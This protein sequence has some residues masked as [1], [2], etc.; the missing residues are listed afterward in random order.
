MSRSNRCVFLCRAT[1][2]RSPSNT[3]QALY[4]RDGSSLSRSGIE[5]PTSTTPVS[6]Q[7]RRR[8]RR[9]RDSRRARPT[10]R[11]RTRPSRDNSRG[12][13]AKSGL[14]PPRASG[15]W[16]WR[17]DSSTSR[18]ARPAPRR[19]ARRRAP[20][21][22]WRR[23]FGSCRRRRRVDASATFTF[24]GCVARRGSRR[25][26]GT[27]APVTRFP[28]S[29]SA[30]AR[31]D[32][33]P[34]SPPEPASGAGRRRGSARRR[35]SATTSALAFDARGDAVDPARHRGARRCETAKNVSDAASA[36]AA[37]VCAPPPLTA[38]RNERRGAQCSAFS[39]RVFA[40][41]RTL[42]RR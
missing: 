19:P 8:A 30:V 31:E 3:Q 2:P 1:R 39:S 24:P 23:C 16:R 29:A 38:G 11:S 5:P 37:S 27:R 13:S 42:Q 4:R 18:G 32:F 10:T 20:P 33:P 22:P 40:C 7:R 21:R 15:S 41:V 9:P 26:D 25:G 14:S 17:T 34:S 6:R 36:V 12:P 28:P 35:S